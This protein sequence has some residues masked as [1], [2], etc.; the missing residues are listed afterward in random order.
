MLLLTEKGNRNE[1]KTEK[2][3]KQG[4]GKTWR[5]RVCMV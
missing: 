4:E 3:E 5:C 1:G 2:G